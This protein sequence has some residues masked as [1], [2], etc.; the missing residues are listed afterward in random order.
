MKMNR[1][2]I[3]VLFI[4]ASSCGSKDDTSQQLP[5]QDTSLPAEE[6]ATDLVSR[7]TLEEKIA[8]MRYEAPA[9][10]RLGVPAYNWWNECLHGVG[11][12]GV[13]TVFPQ[14]IGMASS[15]NAPLMHEIATVISDE[16]RAKHHKFAEQEMRG[17]YMGLT[18]WTPNIN[19][20]RDPRWG[21]GQETY[22]EDPYLTG[23][24]AVNFIKGLQGDDEKYFKTIATAKHYAV[25]N[26]PEPIRHSFNAEVSEQDLWE[27]YLPHFRKTIAEANV[28][29][30]M[31]AY[32]AFREEPCCGSDTLLTNILREQ[33]GFDGYVVSDCW[34]INDF[35]EKGDHE[36]VDTPEQAATMAVKSGTDLNC[37][38]TY[39]ALVQAVEQGLITEEEIDVAVIRLFKARFQLGMFDD[40]KDVPFSK[41][42]YEVVGSE[43][44]HEMALQSSQEAL[45]LLKNEDNMLPLSKDLK[46][47]AVI[48]PNA[49]DH[50]VMLG[51][52]HGTPTQLKTVL[53]GIKDKLSDEVA[54]NYAEGSYIVEDFPTMKPI[55]AKAL[56][57]AGDVNGKGLKAE[58]Y[59]NAD[60]SGEPVETKV[61]TLIDF[62]WY[63]RSPIT[64]IEADT[65]AIRWSGTIT[66]PKSGTYQFGF[67]A[68]H[69]AKVSFNGEEQFEFYNEHHP[70]TNTFEADLEEGKTYPIVIEYYNNG[71]DPQAHLLW[72]IPDEDL[73]TP[74]IEAAKNSDL[75]VMVMGLHPRIEGEE[76]GVKLPGFEGGDRTDIK[77]PEIQKELIQKISSLGKPIVLVMMGGSAVA[78][79]WAN[80]NVPAILYSWYPGEMGGEAI[81]DVLFGD[82]NPSGRLPVTFYKSVDDLPDFTNYDMENRTY[83]FFTGEVLYPFGHGLSYSQ[84]A[85]DSLQI[86][87]SPDA[88]GNVTVNVEVTNTGEWEGMEVVQLYVKD[89]S[90][91]FRVPQRTLGA[92]KKIN[93]EAGATE[94]VSFTLSEKDYAMVNEEGMLTIEPGSFTISVG[95]KQPGFEGLAD[96]KTSGVVTGS[97]MVK[98]SPQIIQ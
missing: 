63:G 49:H 51:N 11:R 30:V 95:G 50:Q 88:E 74:A 46:S 37:G 20:F 72:A 16:A 97:F 59:Q 87:T 94:M 24:L 1:L 45:V 60:F 66:P 13:A 38:D 17:I 54:I 69:G 44:H 29:S 36:V 33:F 56:T 40:P 26:G 32:N 68:A 70:S 34:A 25:H 9:I 75:V 23:E 7:M 27:T 80:Q 6:R 98:G 89:D 76:M 35:Y 47:I 22:G 14:A 3:V 58:Y 96:A 41:I 82:A 2:W 79:N 78:F 93:L 62:Y 28:Q 83:K 5:Y 73:E 43:E 71:T 42:N 10:E 4:W 91:S 64:D 31:C 77:L 19:I 61:D 21:R 57:P 15:W 12:A 39:P 55:P 67:N 53:E 85:Y 18:F 48:G 65:F 92:F 52:Y 84:F 90:A 86:P 8:Q 81:A